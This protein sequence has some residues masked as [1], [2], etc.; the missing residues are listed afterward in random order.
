MVEEAAVGNG[1]EEK[2]EGS[3]GRAIGGVLAGFAAVAALAVSLAI[4]IGP[5]RGAESPVRAAA[6]PATATAIAALPASKALS[7]PPPVTLPSFDLVRVGPDGTA[8]VAGRGQPG[9]RI[10]LRIDGRPVLPV[11]ADARGQFAAFLPL[12]GAPGPRMIGLSLQG[13]GGEVIGPD[14]VIVARPGA[15]DPAPVPVAA[16][17]EATAGLG[18]AVPDVLALGPE[19][20]RVPAPVRGLSIDTLTYEDGG[21]RLGGRA[22]GQGT[23]RLYVDGTHAGD[24]EVAADGTWRLPI[25]ALAPGRHS[26]RADRLDREG[27]VAARAELPFSA[28]PG[29]M[30]ASGEGPVTAATVQPGESLWRIAERRYGNG[31][32]YVRLF[33]ANRTQIL[34]PDLIYPG[35]VLA[36]PD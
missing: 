1:A 10:T 15:T 12:D 20:P 29:T 28:D 4:W 14:E 7:D 30:A 8:L 24:T 32:L 2:G 22:E 35:Q 31:Q 19:G 6:V 16:D 21:I 25:P 5:P 13:E 26:V 3:G 36:L 27:A 17:A 18:A 34:D 33:A 9:A 23:V 11:Q